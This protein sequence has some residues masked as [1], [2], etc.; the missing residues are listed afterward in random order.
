MIKTSCLS[1]LSSC[2]NARLRA[3]LRDVLPASAS[4]TTCRATF[5]SYT[6]RNGLLLAWSLDVVVGLGASHTWAI[7]PALCICG[8]VTSS[9][10]F[11]T[12]RG[13]SGSILKSTFAFGTTVKSH[14]SVLLAI[15]RSVHA[16]M[17]HGMSSRCTDVRMRARRRQTRQRRD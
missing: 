7:T 6:T 4:R 13:V 11:A 17:L 1:T 8:C 3:R 5:A 2:I 10:A 16:R 14:S 15:Y 9:A 12:P